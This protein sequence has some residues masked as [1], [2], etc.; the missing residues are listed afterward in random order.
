MRWTLMIATTAALVACSSNANQTQS[1]EPTS[2]PTAEQSMQQEKTADVKTDKGG[3]HFQNGMASPEQLAQGAM[4]QTSPTQQSTAQEKTAPVAP[5]P[6][7]TMQQ[8]QK[9][10]EQ[11]TQATASTSTANKVVGTTWKRCAVCHNFT[12]TPKVGPGLA[13]IIGRTAGTESNF[14]YRFT[15]YI[16]GKAWVWDEA[17]L[18]KWMCDSKKAIKAFTGDEN[19]QTKMPSQHVCDPADQ[20]SVLSKLRSIS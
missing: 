20:E 17:H 7:S 14:N 9:S 13:G 6:S 12:H 11:A 5:A 10:V 4:Q 1:P 8:V 2:S 16:K 18:K 15:K 3:E 19:A